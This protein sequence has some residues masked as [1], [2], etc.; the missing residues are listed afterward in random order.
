MSFRPPAGGRNSGAYYSMKIIQL[1]I[2]GGRYLKEAVAFFKQE[3]ADII[4]L[5][6]VTSGIFTK[7]ESSDVQGIDVYEYIKKELGYD[8]VFEKCF[9]AEVDGDISHRGNAILSRYPLTDM[10]TEFYDYPFTRFDMNMEGREYAHTQP[11]N[12]IVAHVET[13]QGKMRVM[14]T[15]MAWSRVCEDTERRIGQIK[16][17]ITYLESVPDEQTLLCGDFNIHPQSESLN[18][19]KSYFVNSGEGSI[20]NTLNP[21][22]HPVFF[23]G[24]HPQGLAVD[25]ILTHGLDATFVHSPE[26]TISDH[27]P[28]I[29]EM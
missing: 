6:E 12:F 2:W 20:Q 9:S 5:Q 22:V 21:A 15:H 3:N 23:N 18:I 16:K 19:F 13:P 14:C 26:I 25:Y 24:D 1:N 17:I 7:A 8:G 27:L 11:Q 4:C 29:A 10:Y 28:V